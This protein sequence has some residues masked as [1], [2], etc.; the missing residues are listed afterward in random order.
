V[1]DPLLDFR[2][3]LWIPFTS[4]HVPSGT[5]PTPAQSAFMWSLSKLG[6]KYA[7]VN[8]PHRSRADPTVPIRSRHGKLIHCVAILPLIHKPGYS[9]FLGLGRS[10]TPD[11]ATFITTI[12]TECPP[13]VLDIEDETIGPLKTARELSVKLISYSCLGRGLTTSGYVS[14]LSPSGLLEWPTIR[15]N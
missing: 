12:Q 6:V 4:P 7:N 8:H 1:V 9:S 13:S 3:K 10:N 5:P 15:G 14:R 11:S 2:L